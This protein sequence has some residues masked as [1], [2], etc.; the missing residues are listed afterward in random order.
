[1]S[2]YSMVAFFGY[3]NNDYVETDVIVPEEKYDQ[4]LDLLDKEGLLDPT[5]KDYFNILDENPGPEYTHAVTIYSKNSCMGMDTV[6]RF[7]ATYPARGAEEAEKLKD[8]LLKALEITSKTD[9]SNELSYFAE[10]QDI[11]EENI[12]EEIAKFIERCKYYAG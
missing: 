12:D 11:R 6:V 3:Y 8:T 9:A 1:M 7:K 2:N 10:I 4:V 5:V